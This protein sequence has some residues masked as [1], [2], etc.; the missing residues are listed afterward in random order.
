MK[1]LIIA[2]II[3]ITFIS[4]KKQ[5]T[6]QCDGFISQNSETRT[7]DY[8]YVKQEEAKTACDKQTSLY[9]Q[10]YPSTNCTLTTK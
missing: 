2:A 4:C 7:F 8:K 3:A 5:Y 9:R 1:K 10:V 6:C